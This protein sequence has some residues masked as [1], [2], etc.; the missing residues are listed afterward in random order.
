MNAVTATVVLGSIAFIVLGFVV[1]SVASA[2]RESLR[3]V[4]R[5]TERLDARHQ[6]HLDT[7]LD[8]LMA[9]KWED[10]ATIRATDED[11]EGGFYPP[12]RE[13]ADTAVMEVQDTKWGHLNKVNERFRLSDEEE[14]LIQ[15]DFDPEG[16]PRKG[17]P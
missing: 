16:N 4:S 11:V 7:V 5:M 13:D 3:T 17:S 8:R 9:I 15:E 1:L 2:F 14:T 6:R 12:I 10:Y